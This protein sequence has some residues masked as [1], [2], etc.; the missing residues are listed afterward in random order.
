[1]GWVDASGKSNCYC[2]VLSWRITVETL[3]LNALRL[4]S[5][6]VD[7]T[8]DASSRNVSVKVGDGGG[9]TLVVRPNGESSWVLRYSSNAA[10]ET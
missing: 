6:L 8:R 3:L 7:A 5:R 4:K 2:G 9:L 10:G 1:M